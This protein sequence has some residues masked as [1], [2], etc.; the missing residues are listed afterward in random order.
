VSRKPEHQTPMG[1]VAAPN[2]NE[3]PMKSA[4]KTLQKK[5]KCTSFSVVRKRENQTVPT[6]CSNALCVLCGGLTSLRCL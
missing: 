4:S 1:A 2:A 6:A 5:K 3:P